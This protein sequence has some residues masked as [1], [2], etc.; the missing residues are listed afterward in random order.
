MLRL[1]TYSSLLDF[2]EK[3]YF[4]EFYRLKFW[5]CLIEIRTN[6]DKWRLTHTT[7]YANTIAN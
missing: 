5:S 7:E 3:V 1:T 2:D 4:M 6:F